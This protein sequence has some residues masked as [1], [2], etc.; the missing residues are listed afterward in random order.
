MHAV[1]KAMRILLL[2]LTAAGSAIGQKDIF[3]LATTGDGGVAYFASTLA[4]VESG[5]SVTPGG[6]PGRIFRIGP[7]GF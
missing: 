7:E 2:S 4:R 6:A 5:E 3:D 1:L